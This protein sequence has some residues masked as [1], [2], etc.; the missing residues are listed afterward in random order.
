MPTKKK[1]PYG[2]VDLLAIETAEEQVAR[3]GSASTIPG[4]YDKIM[5]LP[6][7]LVST[8]V[9]TIDRDGMPVPGYRTLCGLALGGEG[10]TRERGR[11]GQFTNTTDNPN[12]ATCKKCLAK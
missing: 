7:H 5:S 9:T 3:I 6:M 12:D 8:E 11:L 10:S 4:Q 1:V 2:D